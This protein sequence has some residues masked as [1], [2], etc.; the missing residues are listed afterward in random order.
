MEDKVVL[1]QAAGL[2]TD[3][4]VKISLSSNELASTQASLNNLRWNILTNT[5]QQSIMR[6]FP[7]F[8]HL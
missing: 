8:W 1:N 3:G 6:S 5:A 7:L 4:M 2:I